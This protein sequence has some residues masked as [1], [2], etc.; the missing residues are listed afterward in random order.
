[1]YNTVSSQRSTCTIVS[2]INKLYKIIKIPSVCYRETI[3]FC[4][5]CFPRHRLVNQHFLCSH[6]MYENNANKMQ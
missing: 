4:S 5:Q 3:L 2:Y 6:D 1:M